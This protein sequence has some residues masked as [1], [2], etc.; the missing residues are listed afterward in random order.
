MPFDKNFLLKSAALILGPF[1]IGQPAVAQTA[2][3]PSEIPESVLIT[4]SRGLFGLRTDLL[5]SSYTIIQPVDLELRQVEIVSDV[6]RDVPGV[7]VNRTGTVG[8]QTEVRIRGA[9]GNHTLTLIDGIEASDPF[10]GEFDWAGLLADESAKIE[11]LRGQQS[12]LYGSTAIG[13]VIQYIT[14]TGAEAPGVR[15]HL[16]G[17][18]FDTLS[19]SARVAGVTG[20]LDYALSGS[21]SRTGGIVGARNGVRHDGA[22]NEGFSGKFIY[23]V[24]DNLHITAVGRYSN[25]DAETTPQAFPFPADASFG[26]T[27]DTLP[28]NPSVQVADSYTAKSLYGLL[29]GDLELMGGMWTH[30]LT[31]QGVSGDRKSYDDIRALSGDDYGTRQKASYTTTINFAT[32]NLAHA[33][34]FAADFKRETYQNK[35]VGAPPTLANDERHLDNA[36]FVGQY[37]LRIGDDIGFGAAVRYDDNTHFQDATTY[38]VQASYRPM[39]DLRLRAAAGT[40]ITNPTNF[41]LFGFDPATFIGNPNLK[42]ERSEGWEAGLDYDLFA[43]MASVGATYFDSRLTDEIITAFT[44]AFLSTPENLSTKSTQQGVELWGS[45]RISEQWRIDATWTNLHALEGSPAV[46]EVRRPPN[47][48]SL[49]VSWRAA[50]DRFGANLTLRYNGE[51][52]DFQFTPAATLRVPMKAYTLVNLGADYRLDDNWQIYGR[53]EN[54]FD[55]K[56]EEV[57]AFPSPGIAVYGGLRFRMR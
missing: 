36:G 45:A 54:L 37:D 16:E 21:L 48:A 3:A 25:V 32:D 15:A 10:A 24:K 28:G 46:Q 6:L 30:S 51:Q 56:Y 14:L 20:A 19:G 55:E 26:L 12:A 44:P 7:A 9:E 13:G 17:G 31:L 1:W 39:Q 38:R 18:S 52:V 29:R 5:G 4:G 27:Y 35:A 53:V 47:I 23:T 2:Q 57:F 11:V 33:L 43:G 40:G 8:G 34:T 49:N 41:E 22:E 50:D 42:P